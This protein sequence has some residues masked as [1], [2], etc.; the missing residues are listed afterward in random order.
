MD[1]R[2]TPEQEQFIRHAIE[3]GR[4][5]TPDEAMREAVGLL[6]E[7]ER[8]IEYLQA[9]ADEGI[10]DLENGRFT[11]YTDDTLHRM[12]EDVRKD[13]RELRATTHKLG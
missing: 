13:G 5:A 12:M 6:E 1:V 9:I 4:F 7:R 8:E 3:S 2:L 11:D 10:A